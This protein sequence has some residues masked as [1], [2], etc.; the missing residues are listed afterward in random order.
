MAGFI[1]LCTFLCLPSHLHTLNDQDLKSGSPTS[2]VPFVFLL[3]EKVLLRCT[4]LCNQGGHGQQL[5][6]LPGSD[7]AISWLWA[8]QPQQGLRLF[9]LEAAWAGIRV[10]VEGVWE[11]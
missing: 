6:D 2:S 5:P 3:P 7:N 4:L 10:A 9:S 8:W 11:Q 1:K